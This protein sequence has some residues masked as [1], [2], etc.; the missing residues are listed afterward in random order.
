MRKKQAAIVS[1]VVL[2]FIRAACLPATG[3]QQ[4]TV[5]KFQW[6]WR[7]SQELPTAQN[8]ANA[9]ISHTD[10]SDIAAAI[11][12]RLKLN[13]DDSSDRQLRNAALRTRVQFID[14]NHDGT[15]EIIA[16]SMADCSPTGNCSIWVFQ[17]QSHAY[18][19]LL[20]GFGQT[21]TIQKTRTNGY[22]DIVLASH[23]SASDSGL[24]VFRYSESTYVD[25]SCYNASWRIL[26][27][28]LY[29]DL[30]EPRLTPCQ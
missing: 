2:L 14:L 21:F 18:K 1:A 9:N 6:H 24:T 11:A 3:A 27:A 12:A 30:K 19:L 15:P 8:L 25:T 10:K 7:D 5:H 29:V 22:N 26:Q 23:G 13:D 20:K 17:K 16:Q 4:Q 28:G